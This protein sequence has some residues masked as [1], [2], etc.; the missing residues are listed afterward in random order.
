V[1]RGLDAG[2]VE[3]GAQPVAPRRADD[4]E[5]VD[6]ARTRVHPRRRYL[7]HAGQ[8]PVVERRHAPAA[9]GPVAQVRELGGEQRGLQ[10]VEAAVDA[11]HVVLV[12]HQRTVVGVHAAASRQLGVARHDGAR[13]APGAE[14]LAGIEAE[15]A[16]DAERAHRAAVE[17][18]EVRLGAV[19]DDVQSAARADRR[20]LL[21]PRRLPVE[22]H[23]QH[24]AGARRDRRLEPRRVEVV[25]LV[26]V[27]EHDPRARLGDSLGGR[28]PAR[29]RHDHLVAR[30][31][32]QHAQH[33]VDGVGAV[34]DGH[35]VGGTGGRGEL[36]LEGTHVLATD[37]RRALDHALQGRVELLP[38][39]E[40]LGLQVDERDAHG[41]VRAQ[42]RRSSR[43]GLPA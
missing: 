32:A 17:L 31:D 30:P 37:V 16:G 6:V 38:M 9:G 26:D 11:L 22:V 5:V 34:R 20:D 41:S 43:A 12:L 18:R 23:R 21:H 1:D 28:D 10:P 36:L 39:G 3:R 13:V 24:R 33:D 42:T 19:L 35:T 4:V 7:R 8:Q 2:G 40:V 27:G 14:V 29:R 25:V 15:G